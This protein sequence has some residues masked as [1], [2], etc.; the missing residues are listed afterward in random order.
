MTTAFH[1]L[2][3]GTPLTVS[4]KNF[5]RLTS[6]D[7][8]PD[9]SWLDDESRHD[10]FHEGMWHMIGIQASAT[11]L[12]PLGGHYVTQTVTS[13]GLWGIESD[14]DEEYF[15]QVFAD[16]CANLTDMLQALGVAVREA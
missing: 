7:E 6:V 2:D 14:S 8:H 9:I 5:R 4:R 16:E 1:C 11:F 10:A 12:I 3:T 15:D 13:P